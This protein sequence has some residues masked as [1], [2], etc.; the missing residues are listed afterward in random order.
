MYLNEMLLS[1][2]EQVRCCAAVSELAH[3]VICSRIIKI[4]VPSFF[5]YAYLPTIILEAVGF[6][7]EFFSRVSI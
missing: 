6:C 5:L 7:Y 3:L 4:L 1:F 2:C